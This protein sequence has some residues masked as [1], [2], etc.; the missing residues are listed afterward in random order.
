[1]GLIFLEVFI[2]FTVLSLE[3]HQVRLLDFIAND[4]WP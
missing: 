3:F 2:V 1:M 4:E